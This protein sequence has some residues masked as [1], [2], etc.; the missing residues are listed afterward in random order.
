VLS[1]DTT[2]EPS[3]ASPP[4]GP[5]RPAA[6]VPPAPAAASSAE[7]TT[8]VTRGF[9][10]PAELAAAARLLF[11]ARYREA[12]AS[13]AR[14]R[15]SPGPAAGHAALLRAATQY[16]LYLVGG[17]REPSLLEQARQASAET[18]RLA[19]GLQPDPRAFSPRFLR[20]FAAEARR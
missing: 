17:E 14:Q 13:L 2:A 1:A 20:F 9:T 16:S 12:A 18:R 15:Y 10:P 3:A 5:V 8:A 4:A 7:S 6:P 11:S 19:P